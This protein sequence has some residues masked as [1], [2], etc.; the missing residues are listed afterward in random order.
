MATGANRQLERR[1]YDL[2]REAMLTQVRFVGAHQDCLAAIYALHHN[3][4][5]QYIPQL[6]GQ[7]ISIVHYRSVLEGIKEKYASSPYIEVLER[8]IAESEAFNRVLDG[9]TEV[10][11]PDLELVDIMGVKH[12]LG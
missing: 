1:A 12:K 6:E 5:E 11:Y 4:A 10:S 9:M 2:A 3:V 7:G 8:S